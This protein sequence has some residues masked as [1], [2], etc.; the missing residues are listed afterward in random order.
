MLKSLLQITRQVLVKQ[1]FTMLSVSHLSYFQVEARDERQLL[2]R[3]LLRRLLV[4][5][6]LAA[7]DLRR[8]AQILRASEAVNT[9]LDDVMFV[10]LEA[11]DSD[12]P[13]QATC[14]RRGSFCFAVR[15]RT[16][17]VEA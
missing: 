5:L 17:L 12:S 10:R 11:D 14:Q 1:R 4:H 3:Q 2:H 15:V 7:L 6:T 9:I 13:L 8:T 16:Q